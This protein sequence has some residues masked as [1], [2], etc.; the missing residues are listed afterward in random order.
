M[1]DVNY[2]SIKET[3]SSLEIAE[4]TGKEHKI[5]MRDIRNLIDNL[6]NHTGTD[7]YPLMKSRK[8]IIDL[9]EHNIN[10]YPI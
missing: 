8:I 5:V 4:T 6:N 7:L 1:N 2:L 3:M 10:T 9:I